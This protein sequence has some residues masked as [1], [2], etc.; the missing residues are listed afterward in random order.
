MRP[1]QV[2]QIIKQLEDSPR[3]L[4]RPVRIDEQFEAL[5]QPGRGMMAFHGDSFVLRLRDLATA[6][7]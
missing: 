6:R 2:A 1:N 3:L 7:S 5:V 4:R